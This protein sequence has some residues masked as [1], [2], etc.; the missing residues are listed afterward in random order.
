MERRDL[1]ESMTMDQDFLAKSTAVLNVTKVGKGKTRGEKDKA[2]ETA[3]K[4][5]SESTDSSRNTLIAE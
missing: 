4:Q 1:L 2:G 5:N 3:E